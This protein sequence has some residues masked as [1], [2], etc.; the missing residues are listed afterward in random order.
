MD[1]ILRCSTRETCLR[2]RSA[3]PEKDDLAKGRETRRSDFSPRCG[4]FSAWVQLPIGGLHPLK[5]ACRSLGIPLLHESQASKPEAYIVAGCWEGAT[6][7]KA[8][9]QQ[10]FCVV[11]WSNIAVRFLV[12]AGVWVLRSYLENGRVPDGRSLKLFSPRSLVCPLVRAH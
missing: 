2:F 4:F 9:L 1:T 5:P 11:R 10:S 7:F 8:S 6:T 3:E 12:A